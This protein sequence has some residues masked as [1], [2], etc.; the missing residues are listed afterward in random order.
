MPT[1]RLHDALHVSCTPCMPH[2]VQRRKSHMCSSRCLHVCLTYVLRAAA[3]HVQ[4]SLL[5]CVHHVCASRCCFTCAAVAACMCA[6]RMCFAL[7][8]YMCSSRCLIACVPHVRTC[9]TLL[10][11]LTLGYIFKAALHRQT[12]ALVV[13]LAHSLCSGP[14]SAHCLPARTFSTLTVHNQPQSTALLPPPQPRL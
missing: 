13:L 4:Q 9:F 12:H 7:L 1:C 6:S 5:A 8:L 2:A 3:L 14:C 10:L 11:W